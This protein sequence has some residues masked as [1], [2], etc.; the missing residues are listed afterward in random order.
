[1]KTGDLLMSNRGLTFVILTRASVLYIYTVSFSLW[2][3]YV[4]WP[5]PSTIAIGYSEGI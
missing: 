4:Y 1:M 2:E 3:G 5:K